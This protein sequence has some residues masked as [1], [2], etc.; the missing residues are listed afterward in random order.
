M[1]GALLTCAHCGKGQRAA[2]VAMCRV[3]EPHPINQ[4]PACIEREMHFC[5]DQCL[6]AWR[7]NNE[8]DHA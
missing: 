8:A 3:R 6:H 1:T 2:I 5:D 7:N 4:M